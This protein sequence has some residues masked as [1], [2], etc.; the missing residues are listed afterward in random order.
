MSIMGIWRP[1]MR[2]RICLCPVVGATRCSAQLLAC[3]IHE[4]RVIRVMV[5]DLLLLEVIDWR[6][7][8]GQLLV[9]FL[10]LT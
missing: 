2:T 6:L 8:S 10:N 9:R 3:R 7:A 1:R 5:A 4:M